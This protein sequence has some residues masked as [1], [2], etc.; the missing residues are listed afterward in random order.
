MEAEIFPKTV[1]SI[2]KNT[3]CL[4]TQT[5]T[6]WTQPLSRWRTAWK[7]KVCRLC[8]RGSSHKKGTGVFFIITTK[9]SGETFPFCSMNSNIQI[10]KIYSLT[11][12]LNKQLL[13]KEILH[14]IFHSYMFRLVSMAPSSGWAFKK[15]LYTIENVLLITKS[16]I[17]GS[18]IYYGLS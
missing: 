8:G 3:R 5:V 4:G 13:S 6:V 12:L 11:R 1:L 15:V 2:Y 16:H 18:K 14:I 9:F 10:Y 17:T 7:T